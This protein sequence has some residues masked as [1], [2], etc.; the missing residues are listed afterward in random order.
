[1]NSFLVFLEQ[2]SA[3]SI[4]VA[5]TN[6]RSILDHALFRRFDVVIKY[7]LPD[8]AYASAVMKARLGPMARGIR[9][10]SVGEKAS[11]L[12]HAELVKAAETA[13]K[14]VILRGQ[15]RVTA[16]DLNDALQAR[17]ATRGE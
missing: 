16:V 12:S 4:V 14:Q 9:W 1:M 13:A 15:Q 8:V 17:R 2:A 5:A 11:G 7:E 6:H 10:A 3:E